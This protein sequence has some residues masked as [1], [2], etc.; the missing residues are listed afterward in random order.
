VK[1]AWAFNPFD[2]NRRLQRTAL[3]LLQRVRGAVEPIEIVYVAS[4]GEIQLAVAFDVPVKQRYGRY[5]MRLIE[6][7]VHRL[8]IANA[9]ITV[10]RQSS[11]SLTAGARTL[12]QHLVRRRFDLTLLAS[13]AR[14][15]VRRLAL[16]S[17]AET[18]VHLAKTDLLVFNEASRVARAQ[19]V[20]LFAHDLSPA[21]DRGLRQSIRYAKAWG[22]VLHVVHVP[23]VGEDVAF[24][25]RGG[26]VEVYRRR[27]RQQ[28]ARIEAAVQRA[29]LA[30]SAVIAQRAHPVAEQ[31][32]QRLAS[33]GADLLLVVGKSG[34]FTGLLGGSVTR[35]LLR[36]APVPVLVIKRAGS[37][38]SRAGHAPA[39]RP[40]A[41]ARRSGSSRG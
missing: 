28:V 8:A 15:G 9:R 27:V 10:L 37:F 11:A 40:R 22:S 35:K 17:F 18:L 34:R 1:I 41:A 20:L 39:S 26:E 6:R 12:A 13:H 16:G 3:E 30:G 32:L 24:G 7:A 2:D 5:P 14:T 38:A 23:M 29:G 36:T 19:K 31:V 4:P 21:G 25:G 33:V